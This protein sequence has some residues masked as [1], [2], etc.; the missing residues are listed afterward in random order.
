MSTRPHEQARSEHVQTGA[1]RVDRS[2]RWPDVGRAVPQHAGARRASPNGCSGARCEPLPS[3]STTA[4]GD[5]LGAGGTDGPGDAPG[6][7][8]RPSSAGSAPAA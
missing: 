2:G 7:P 5:G 4:D 6:P 1:A 8:G 3:G